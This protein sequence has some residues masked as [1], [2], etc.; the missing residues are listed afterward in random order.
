MDNASALRAGVLHRQGDQI[1]HILLA[2]HHM[3][4]VCD[5]ASVSTMHLLQAETL[6]YVAAKALLGAAHGRPDIYLGSTKHAIMYYTFQIGAKRGQTHQKRLT[7]DLAGG[8]AL[9]LSCLRRLGG[10]ASGLS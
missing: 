10:D 6:K 4:D 7:C 9:E 3:C 1:Y 8:L 2:L 5:H